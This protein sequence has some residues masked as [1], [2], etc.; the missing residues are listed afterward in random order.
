MG[1]EAGSLAFADLPREMD[2]VCRLILAKN[3]KTHKK[4][5]KAFAGR[6]VVKEYLALVQGRISDDRGR[7][8][9]A[10]ERDRVQRKRMKATYSDRGRMSVSSFEVIERLRGATLVKVRIE[11]GRTHQI[12][13]HMAFLGHPLLGDVTY[14][15]RRIDGKAMHHLHSAKLSMTHPIT[16]KPVTWESPL[17]E[18]FAA[19]V[20][21]FRGSVAATTK[22]MPQR[23]KSAR[24]Q[25]STL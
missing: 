9:V 11:T 24:V 3:E 21:A 15:G 23:H 1:Y 16:G 6:T 25:K 8:E 5:A 12:R 22:K 14:G 7:I 2:G 10:I 19:M 4:L 18:S 17:P 20:V 13:V